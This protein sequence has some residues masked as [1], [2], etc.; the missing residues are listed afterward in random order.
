VAEGHAAVHAA[1]ALFA[2]LLHRA[3]EKEL[4]IVA[5]ALGRI[6]LWDTVALDL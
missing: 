2:Q 3:L 4:A 1:G 5:G 6:P